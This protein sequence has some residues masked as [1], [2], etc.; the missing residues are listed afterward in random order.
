MVMSIWKQKSQMF[1]SLEQNRTVF[2]QTL[3]FDCKVF[4]SLFSGQPLD[5]PWSFFSSSQ[6]SCVKAD[7]SIEYTMYTLL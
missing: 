1:E 2:L 6:K 4:L 3:S 7:N 5:K